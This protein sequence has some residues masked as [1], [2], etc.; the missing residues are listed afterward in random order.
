MEFRAAIDIEDGSDQAHWGLARSYEGIG[1]FYEAVDELR[2][3]IE[4]NPDNLEAKVK[5]GN[6]LL[7]FNPPQ[8][9]EAERLLQDVLARDPKFIEGHILKASVMAAR[10]KTEE[11][12]L[13]VL[14]YA[15]SLDPGRT[16]SYVS[17][18][19]F[20]A[21]SEK[22]QE[23][24]QTLQKGISVNPNKA[25]GYLEYGRFL[26]LRERFPEAEAQFAKAIEV[27]PKNIEAH[28]TIAQFYTGQKQFDKAEQAYKQLVQV[29]ENSP[30]SR[31][32][33][34]NFY[35]FIDRQDEA[36][37]IL[38][39]ILADFPQYVR[40]R[41]RLGEIY[42]DRGETEKVGEQIE[43]LLAIND[44]DP[45]ALMLR[46]R[47]NLQANKANEAV[48]DLEEILKKKP[49]QKDALF[50]MTQARIDLGQVDQAR[51]FIG[52]LEK[53]HPNFLRSKLLKIQASFAGGEAGLALV[54]SN[55]LLQLL[56][57]TS[58]DSENSGQSL[59]DL[60]IRAMSSRGLANLQMGNIAQ[61]RQDLEEVARLKPNST[62]GM[63]NLAKVFVA[64]RNFPE[65]INL[66]EKALAADNRN[67]DALSGL[68]G[69]LTKQKQFA[70]AQARIDKSMQENAGRS[71]MMPALH[72]LKS[73][74]YMA[75][76]NFSAA[77]NELK[78]TIEIDNNYL[79]AYSAY[80]SLLIERNQIDAGIEQYRK[81]VERQ[82]SATVYT[83][84]GMLEDTRNNA[85]EAEKNYRKALEI[86][87]DS[88]IASNNLA[89]LIASQRGNLDEALQ[90]AQATVSRNPNT[91]GYYD[92]LGWVYYQKGL[93]SAAIV[94]LKK[95]VALDAAEAARSGSQPNPDYR[96][97]LT[98]ALNSAG[99][100]PSV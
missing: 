87:P 72:Y 93:Y 85:A 9:D 81:V 1:Q 82:P 73:D 57:T 65:A 27:E 39:G 60:R 6:Y 32:S 21:K 8:I 88:P 29:E 14:N 99:G 54:Q 20:Y 47:Y 83:L 92:T 45:D 78:R 30:E 4:L 80:A 56:K 51:A 41:Y 76:G 35:A 34:A 59:E 17:L 19:R 3:T 38:N 61:A 26:A 89:W 46:V 75:E 48:K 70:E 28:E 24:E 55:E 36:I 40:A 98:M 94:H 13:A 86:E 67:F 71:E 42:L 12:V 16:E 58:P 5:L 52:D 100:K 37:Q 79:P 11:E 25:L 63:I 62:A 53:Y 23:A 50:Y 97:R 96:Q 31:I 95:A 44:H 74:V 7:V 43:Q 68:T 2:R 15:I 22:L 69:V 66:F 33:L 18:A 84:L 77:E 49:N 91:A 64:E 10:G 90:L